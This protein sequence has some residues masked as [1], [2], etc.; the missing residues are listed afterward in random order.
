MANRHEGPASEHRDQHVVY[1][2]PHCSE[3]EGKGEGGGWRAARISIP[4]LSFNSYILKRAL[5][6]GQGLIINGFQNHWVE[7]V[8][9]TVEKVG[10]KVEKGASSIIV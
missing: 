8:G 4:L 9:L 3:N 5:Q 6:A 10:L 2:L 7:K 1:L